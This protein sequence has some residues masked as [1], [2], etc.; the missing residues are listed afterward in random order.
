MHKEENK[1]KYFI[2][3]LIAMLLWGVAWTS[4]KAAV[5]HSNIQVASFW[6][7]TISFIGMIPVMIY[8]KRSLK[9]DFLGYIYMIL[10]GLLS[11]AFSYLF[12]AG[13]A[14][15]EA[16]YGGTMVTSLVPLITYFLSILI[17]R[18]KVSA[19]QVF[20]LGIGVFGAIVLLKIPMEGLGFLNL[21][22]IYFLVCAIVWSFV[23]VLT[24]K[25]SKR[26]D[27]MFYTL[28]IFGVTAFTN[29]IFA[30]PHHPFEIGLYDSIFWLNISFV[31]LF[32]GTFAMAIFFASASRIGAHN[33]GVFMF[34]VPVGA[35]ISS[36]FAYDEKIAL[37]TILGCL[38]SLVA[39]ILFNKKS[40]L[41]K[42]RLKEEELIV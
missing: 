42:M 16:G 38:L 14:H 35:I 15:G 23:T 30:L 6:R 4:G 17:F 10:A 37:S 5:E 25:A 31:G 22:S 11:A 24:Q 33:T 2:G 40:K 7:Y 26:V 12:F 27:P 18:T 13:L 8:M 9:T 34:I 29:M 32:S 3:M 21:D 39:V 1:T 20:A 41:E 28:V 36:Y 19:K